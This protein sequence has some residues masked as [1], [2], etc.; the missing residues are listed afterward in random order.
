MA[1]GV[2][3]EVVVE[4]GRTAR[5]I[6]V[7]LR[8][9]LPRILVGLAVLVTAL[10]AVA[11]AGA[12]ADDLAI[13]RDPGT[14]TAEVLDAGFGRTLIRFPAAEGQLEVPERGVYYPRGL[15]TGGT[16]EV[17]YARAEPDLVRV[18]GRT[19]WTGLPWL[20]AFTAG[21][22]LVFGG[23]AVL[24]GRRRQAAHQE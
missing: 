23:S 11:F 6:G 2:A 5:T 21:G 4:A 15:Q 20:L 22:W 18:A 8:R 13:D 12:V 10:C 16:V 3:A 1:G 17:E 19:A 14:A 7:A 9:A 24:V